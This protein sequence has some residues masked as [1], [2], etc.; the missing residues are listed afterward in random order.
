MERCNIIFPL[1]P[2]IRL[3]LFFIFLSLIAGQTYIV[4]YIEQKIAE[5]EGKYTKRVHPKENK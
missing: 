4:L 3:I 5:D 2:K 1:N